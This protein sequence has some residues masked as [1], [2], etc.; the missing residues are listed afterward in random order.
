MSLIE[1]IESDLIA[2]M[3]ARDQMTLDTLRLLRAAFKNE[4]IALGHTL[5]NEEILKVLQR[6]IKQRT[7]A[8]QQ[9]RQ[10]ERAAAAA[11][12]DNEAKKRVKL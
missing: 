6:Q 11:K 7:E 10:G 9:Y 12:E 1:Q 4:Q 3:K 8:A 2:A 5:A